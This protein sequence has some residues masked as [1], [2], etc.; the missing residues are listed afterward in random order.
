MASPSRKHSD[1]IAETASSYPVTGPPIAGGVNVT[2][3]RT[4]GGRPG[5]FSKARAVN[6]TSV[7]TPGAP[8]MCVVVV[9]VVDVVVVE[10]VVVVPAGRLVVD[11]TSDV[12][13]GVATVVVVSAP[14]AKGPL[15]GDYGTTVSTKETWHVEVE[16]IRHVPDQFLKH[17]AVLEALAKVIGPLVRPANGLRTVKGCRIYSTIGSS[18]R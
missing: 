6:T 17:P 16:N 10:D 18:V 11:G 8:V 1:D 15:R 5:V 2:I 4:R 7:G 13:G 12:V 9:V 14:V 3:T